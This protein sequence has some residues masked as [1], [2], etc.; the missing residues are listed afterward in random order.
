MKLNFALLTTFLT[1]QTAFSA[2]SVGS[3]GFVGFN[4]DGDDDF[5]FVALTAIPAN[6]S[7]FFTDDEWNGSSFIRGEGALEWIAPASGVTVGQVVTIKGG[8]ATVDIGSVSDSYGTFALSTSGDEIFAYQAAS[9]DDTPTAFLSA[10]TNNGSGG[11]LNLD[12]TGLTVGTS[13]VDFA[14]EYGDGD[15]GGYYLGDRTSE[16]S[17]SAYAALINN[18]ANWGV[19]TSTG[20]NAVPF[21]AGDFSVVPEPSVALLGG[22][23]FLSILRRRRQPLPLS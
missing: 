13:A 7:I 5:A 19:E 1:S 18:P 2:L 8:P 22:L 9:Y 10:F 11:S 16:A 4:V 20:V 23:G 12:N 14:A 3:I 15:D 6:E 21:F 17:F